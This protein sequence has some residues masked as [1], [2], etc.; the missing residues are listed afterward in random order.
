MLLALLLLTV[1]VTAGALLT[2]RWE[3]RQRGRLGPLGLSLVC[4]M[5]L[6]PNLVLEYATRLQAPDSALDWLGVVVGSAGLLLCLAGVFA[7]R[8]VA[9]VMCL[10]PGSLAVTGPYRWSRNPQYLGWL[11]FL[12]GFALNDWS[13]WCLAALVVVA[14]SLHLLVLIEEE[15]LRR[16]FGERY[17]GFCRRTP[18]YL[19]WSARPP[20]VE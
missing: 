14:V 16:V 17:V 20:G 1:P 7:F 9:Q 13:Y 6:V 10:D 15:H 5:L 2:A 8:S 11:L 19:G 12:L 18:R 4:T 3:Y